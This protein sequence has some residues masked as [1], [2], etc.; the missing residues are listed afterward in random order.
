MKTA[1]RRCA[2]CP[3]GAPE[4]MRHAAVRDAFLAACGWDVAVRKPGN[5]SRQ[6]DG[7]GMQAQTFLDSAAASVD[8][9]CVPGS[10]VGAR[11]E[12]AIAASWARVGCN[13]NL[14]IVLLCAPMAAAAERVEA[15]DGLRAAIADVIDALDVA[16]A[17][18]AFR[19]IVQA[20]P[21]GLG[22]AADGDVR[23]PPRM[24]LRE[25]MTLAAGRDR[26]AA[27]YRD[28]L[29]ELFERGLPAL[30]GHA[31][32]DTLIAAPIDAQAVQRLYLAWLASDLDSHIVRKHGVALA[33]SVLNEARLWQRRAEAGEPLDA[34]PRW[35]DWDR[36]LKARRINP[37]TSADLTVATLMLALL[38]ARTPR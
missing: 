36:S 1:T 28:G 30:A 12:A 3:A 25:A 6:S 29:A 4:A 27:Q 9:L 33:Q 5:V 37:G 23:T 31:Q 24:T 10:A 20:N 11:I 22:V 35:T 2:W 7:H 14:G 17:E 15:P 16:D 32:G 19:A 18:A 13:T 38:G 26:I 34:D 21:G 8:G